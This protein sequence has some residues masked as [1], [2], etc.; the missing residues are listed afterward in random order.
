VDGY[1]VG[2]D[3]TVA[4]H[5]EVAMTHWVRP[6]HHPLPSGHR[7]DNIGHDATR[8][9]QPRPSTAPAGL[10]APAPEVVREKVAKPRAKRVRP[11]RTPA[12]PRQA[13]L[14]PCGTV[15]A[16][17]RHLAHNEKPCAACKSARAEND[18][19]RDRG[20]RTNTVKTREQC[21]TDLGPAEHARRKERLCVQ[22]RSSRTTAPKAPTTTT[23]Q[24]GTVAGRP[25]HRRRNELPC[26][27]CKIAVNAA[28]RALRNAA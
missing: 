13:T 4:H 12:A 25:A 14:K 5:H 16:Y 1:R 8:S 3:A 20:Y 19:G 10:F 28:A 24:C 22:C 26:E 9:P 2:W 7:L 23:A 18:C 21:G 27:P 15:A 6:A 11:P 17:R